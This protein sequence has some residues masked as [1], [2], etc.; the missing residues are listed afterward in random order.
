MLDYVREPEAIY[1]RSFELIGE[2]PELQAL[3][4]A[5]R[6][7]ATRIVHACGIPEILGDLRFSDDIAA[8]VPAAL[9]AGADIYCDVDTLRHGV[10]KR[11]L[12]AGCALHCAIGN[13]ETAVHAK[14]NRM[15]RAA[16]Q[17]DLWGERLDGQIVA[18]GNAPTALFRLLEYV[19][20]G[21]AKPAAVIALPVG[22]V[23][24]AES[25]AELAGNPRGIP[26]I[27]LLGR[28]GGVGM[29]QAAVNG[30]AGGLNT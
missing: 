27:T 21:G 5:V 18:I 13:T 22:F 28:W 16:A 17:I 12:P 25:K 24:A 3:P 20:A 26:F 1:A 2:M 4:Q 9:E 6:P 19:D 8:A 30:L 15:T 10:M 29:T 14:A 23:G 11:L 7:V